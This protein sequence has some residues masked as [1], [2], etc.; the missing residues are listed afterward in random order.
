MRR[1]GKLKPAGE[2]GKRRRKDYAAHMRSAYW[3]QVR[4]AVF[5]RDGGCVQRSPGCRGPLTCDHRNYS[6]WRRELED[7]GTMQTLCEYHHALKDG[8][9]HRG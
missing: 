1:G 2:R 7:L 5:A 8:W 3:Q 6:A 4:R 9:K